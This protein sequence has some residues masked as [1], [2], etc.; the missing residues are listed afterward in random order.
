MCW[1]RN[2]KPTMLL[3]FR[4]ACEIQAQHDTLPGQG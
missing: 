1:T 3:Q 4:V 2:L